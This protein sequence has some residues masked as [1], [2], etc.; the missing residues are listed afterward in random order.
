MA[1]DK[2]SK[3]FAPGYQGSE[4]SGVELHVY[5]HGDDPF[6]QSSP[7][8]ILFDGRTRKDKNPSIVSV[9]YQKALGQPSANFVVQIQDPQNT[10]RD[11]IADDDWVD[12]TFT[13][14]GEK[15]HILRGMIDTIRESV[16][17]INGAS[18][19]VVEITGRDHGKVWE[20]TQVFFNRFLVTDGRTVFNE[21][22]EASGAING[23]P[24]ETVFAF[25]Q[26]FLARLS[27]ESLSPSWV[28]PAGIPNIEQGASFVRSVDFNDR[29]GGHTNGIGFTNNPERI[30]VNAWNFD[31]QGNQLWDLAQSWSDPQFCEMY[32]E[33]VDAKTGAIPDPGTA[34]DRTGTQ[35]ALIF[36]DRPFPYGDGG[37]EGAWWNLPTF[38]L[39]RQDLGNGTNVG[40]GGEERI[41]AFM[42]KIKGLNETA[43]NQIELTGV[44]ADLES[45]K[46]HGPRIMSSMSD[47][48]ARAPTSLA[49]FTNFQRTQL[50]DW[51]SLNPVFLN[52]T[53][54]LARGFPDIRVGTRVRV[55][56]EEG[57]E[58]DVTYYVEGISHNW[59]LQQGMRTTLTV[60]RGWRGTDDSLKAA[61]DK[62]RSRFTFINGDASNPD[63]KRKSTFEELSSG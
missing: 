19:N 8:E 26:F 39:T 36:R 56:G 3:R 60:T 58:D 29:N 25:L 45:I 51:F 17:I 53:L 28:L 15:H 6:I 46:R 35:M 23:S 1:L 18:E 40:R 14:F 22:L 42:S 16:T 33:I 55:L 52:G 63:V 32:T 10:I 27:R 12:L 54:P 21:A 47:Y 37:T 4:N 31:P 50:C 20:Q 43:A 24:S 2:Q 30:T 48:V 61:I 34:V 9:Q 11:R 41:N 62:A 57:P 49:R 59:S 44:L 5:S 38:N 13:R 7:G